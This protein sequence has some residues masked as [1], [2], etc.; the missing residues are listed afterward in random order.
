MESLC[1]WFDN[2]WDGSRGWSTN[3][4]T[5]STNAPKILTQAPFNGFGT[6][7]LIGRTLCSSFANGC[8]ASSGKTKGRPQQMP[9]LTWLRGVYSC[10]CFQSVFGEICGKKRK[11]KEENTSWENRNCFS[12][13]HLSAVVDMWI[14]IRH[15]ETLGSD[16]WVLESKGLTEWKPRRRGRDGERDVPRKQRREQT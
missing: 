7:V 15:F 14:R 13:M 6:S 9:K 4:N 11:E 2:T 5:E 10:K 8:H 16:Q 12:W 3:S 1:R